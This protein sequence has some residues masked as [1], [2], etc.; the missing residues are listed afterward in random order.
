M[1]RP[2]LIIRPGRAV[3][4]LYAD[5]E[6]RDF[7]EQDRLTGEDHAA[8]APGKVCARCGWMI[9]ATQ[10]ARRRGAGDGEWVHDM[11]PVADE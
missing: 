1:R 11:C 9:A 4:R 5:L 6:D 3:A 10:T 2:W 7:A 8:H